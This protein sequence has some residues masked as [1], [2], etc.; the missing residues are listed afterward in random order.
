[1]KNLFILYTEL[2]QLNYSKTIIPYALLKNN[3]M[4]KNND[5]LIKEFKID[6]PDIFKDN[7]YEQLINSKDEFRNSI[8]WMH[9]KIGSYII[10]FDK[11]YKVINDLN[12]KTIF[13]MDDLHFAKD[14][15]DNDE[16]FINSDIIVSPSVL[17][18]QNIKHKF[19]EKSKF[20]FYFFNEEIIDNY[21]PKQNYNKRKNQIILSGK[22]NNT[23]L[24]RKQMYRHSIK[25]KDLYDILEHPGYYNMEHE[26]YHVNYYNKISEYKGALFGLANNPLNFLLGKVIEILG[27]GCI[28]FFEY[29][30]QYEEYLGLKEWVHY[31]P[32]YKNKKNEL[33]ID[34]IKFR[35]IIQSE[36]GIQIA[37]NG[38]NYIK[39]N[40]NSITFVN[41]SINIIKK[42]Y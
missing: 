3:K 38:Y 18:F 1:M 14:N 10:V 29:T 41:N 19:Y 26:F 23:Y 5:I 37:I 36:E 4:F 24:S 25:N 11:I 12:I 22:I 15:I 30:Y 27:C 16:R 32:I 34:D 9:Q 7:F 8:L 40:Y 21:N 35:E 6:N 42:L 17:Y 31:V 28:G 39:E 33:D 13:W 2:K 20:L